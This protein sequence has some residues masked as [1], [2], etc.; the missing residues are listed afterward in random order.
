M[1]DLV[2]SL[3]IAVKYYPPD[4][5]YLPRLI[6]SDLHTDADFFKLIYVDPEE[7][8]RCS[9]RSFEKYAN[10]GKIQSGDWDLNT[11][12]Y[13]EAPFYDGIDAAFH[14]S[15]ELR[16]REELSWSKIPFVQEVAKQ[17]DSGSRC[18]GVET[19]SQ[20]NKKCNKVDEIYKSIRDEGYLTHQELLRRGSSFSASLLFLL[21]TRTALTRDEIVV[22]ISRTGELLFYDGK[23]RL[24]IAKIL[25]VNTVPVRVGVRHPRWQAVRDNLQNNTTASSKDHSYEYHPDLQ[26]IK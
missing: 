16:F 14:E 24:S 25:G 1:I 17:I 4:N 13:R 3:G 9:E 18:W 5:P 22:D 2:T 20:L 6:E 8:T 10:V 26:D 23:H 15:L 19:R 21:L 11:E 7:I 12:A